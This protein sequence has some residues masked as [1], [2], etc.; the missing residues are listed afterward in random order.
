MV[1]YVFIVPIQH[2][3]WSKI[4]DQLTFLRVN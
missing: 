4:V 3:I 2:I 1:L